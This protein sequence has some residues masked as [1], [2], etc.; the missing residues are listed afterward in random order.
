MPV[1][2]NQLLRIK[3]I[4]KCLRNKFRPA[5][6][7]HL[8][9][10]CSEALTDKNGKLT[11]VS[12]RTI[13]EDLRIMRSDMLE[14]NAPIKCEDGIYFYD[15]KDYNLFEQN[16]HNTDLL[17]E[18]QDFLVDVFD[19]LPE[20]KTFSLLQSLAAITGKDIPKD[21]DP[22]YR[23]VSEDTEEVFPAPQESKSD[24]EIRFQRVAPRSLQKRTFEDSLDYQDEPQTKEALYNWKSI[25]ELLN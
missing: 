14:F 10:R 18:I 1:N 8:V 4:D 15:D 25:L 22:F 21:L 9:E 16:I 24:P 6:I 17:I 3:T 12:E 7:D 19:S 23:E 5:T 11:G 13:R 2:L 20:T